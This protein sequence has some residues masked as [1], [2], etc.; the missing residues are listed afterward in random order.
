MEARIK[1][2]ATL[3]VYR[4]TNS[5]ILYSSYHHSTFYVKHQWV[6]MLLNTIRRICSSCYI[7]NAKPP[8]LQF[9]FHLFVSF[10]SLLLNK[11]G[12]VENL[13]IHKYC[14][15]KRNKG[16]VDAS[17]NLNVDFLEKAYKIWKNDCRCTKKIEIRVVLRHALLVSINGD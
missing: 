2:G 3:C 17:I 9:K 10:L 7:A 16:I 8:C 13:I 11:S 1:R 4:G 12:L 5:I 15:G 6:I 14:V